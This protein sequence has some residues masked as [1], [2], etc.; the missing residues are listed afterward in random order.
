MTIG[1]FLGIDWATFL[2]VKSGQTL[3]PCLVTAAKLSLASRCSGEE[4]SKWS[5]VAFGNT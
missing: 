1:G 5:I 3:L 2:S 4:F